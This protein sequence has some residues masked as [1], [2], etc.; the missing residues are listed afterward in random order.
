M[1][2]I[3]TFLRGQRFAVVGASR[4]RSKFGNRV[5]RCYWTHGRTAFPVNPRAELVEGQTCYASLADLPEPVDGV[6]IITP[7]RVS[8]AVVDEAIALGLER[9]WFQPGAESAEAT[10]RARQAGIEV[11]AGGPCLLVELPRLRR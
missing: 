4:D 10:A 6:S 8:E 9:L 3:E 11:I 7:P 5:L 2:A 1:G